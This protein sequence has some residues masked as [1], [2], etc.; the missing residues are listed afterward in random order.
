M[1]PFLLISVLPLSMACLGLFPYTAR[2]L[3]RAGAIIFLLQLPVVGWVCLPAFSG[4]SIACGG[5]LMDGMGAAFTIITTLVAAAALVQSALLLPAARLEDSKM[6]DRRFCLFYT[7]SGIFILAMYAVPLVQH[8]GYL[9]IAI[10]AATLMSAPLINYHRSRNSLE[11]T[12]KYLLLCSVGI[13]FAL[14]GTVIIF[15]AQYAFTG[16]GTMMVSELVAHAANLDPRLLRLGFVFCL[17]GY[18]TKAGIFPLH[19][20]LPDAYSE[21]PS[22]VSAMLSGALLNS[23]LVAIW[24]LS[25]IMVAAGQIGLLRQLL[26]PAGAITVIAASIMLVRQHDLKRML[27]YS[28]VEHAGLLTL[29]I[30]IGSGK[31]FILHAFNHS[32]VKVALF[33]LAGGVVHAYGTKALSRLGGILKRTPAWG[34]ALMAGGFAIAGSPPFGTFI[35]EWLLLRDA[36]AAGEVVAVAA[37]VIGLTITLIA[38]TTHMGRAVFGNGHAPARNVAVRTWTLTPAVLLVL[39]LL[40]GVA[41]SPP[42]MQVLSMLAGQGGGS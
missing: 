34:I 24:R 16:G 2:W 5:F 21:A 33:L 23:A 12:W 10:E 15:A 31:I 7:L 35:S 22:V 29:A 17:L 41:I 38:I 37:V 9:W 25:Q 19:N 3:P 4:A 20:W 32:L 30:G 39:S 26:V 11:A 42:V 6:T 14:F 13:A 28:S 40:A 1:N 18:G 36:F 8:L 27:A